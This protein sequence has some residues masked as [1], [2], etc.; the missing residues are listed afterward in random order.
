LRSLLDVTI[1]YPD[2]A[3]DFWEFLAGRLDR[4]IVHV[5]ERSIPQHLLGGDYLRDSVFREQF[6]TWIEELW[7][8]KDERAAAL[9]VE[10]GTRRTD[11]HGSH[12][13]TPRTPSRAFRVRSSPLVKKKLRTALGGWGRVVARLAYWRRCEGALG[14]R[15]A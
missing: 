14:S 6:Q 8:Q 11:R 4:V 3:P 13:Q 15:C 9:L 12:H 2:G 7:K 10:H 1:V 5:E